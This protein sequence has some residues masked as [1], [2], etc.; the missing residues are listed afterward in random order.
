MVSGAVTRQKLR[1]NDILNRGLLGDVVRNA[2][3][4]QMEELQAQM[5]FL[6][7]PNKT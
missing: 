3:A 5:G 1:K 6:R 7:P 4:D 2:A